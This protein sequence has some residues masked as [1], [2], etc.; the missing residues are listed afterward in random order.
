MNR[1]LSLA[2]VLVLGLAACADN[3]S[4]IEIAGRA[5]PSDVKSCLYAVGGQY[6]LG[7]AVYDTTLDPDYTIVLYVNNNLADPTT[8]NPGSLIAAKTWRVSAV[9]VRLN[10]QP[11][12]DKYGPS[13]ALLPVTGE[14]V[15]GSEGV[16]IAPGANG[17]VAADV[18]SAD[19]A[20]AIR[21][22][23]TPTAQQLVLGVTLEGQTL[24]GARL[25]TGEWYY[26]LDVG[27]GCLAGLTCPTGQTR[28]TNTCRGAGQIGRPFCSTGG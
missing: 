20:A 10:P 5:A 4:S 2:A 21:G 8:L 27:A 16:G 19:V 18:M 25:D 26:T 15:L 13:P 12:V 1:K 22:A 14:S 23:A 24:D 3:R 6:L 9:K 28:T 17:V 11:Y 7:T